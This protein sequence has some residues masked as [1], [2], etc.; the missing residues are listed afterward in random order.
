MVIG[1]GSFSHFVYRH[2]LPSEKGKSISFAALLVLLLFTQTLFAQGP[3][4]PDANGMVAIPESPNPPRLVNDYAGVLSDAEEQQLEAKLVNIDKGGIV[5]IAIVTVNTT[6]L[7]PIEDYSH[8]LF[9]KWGIGQ[10]SKNNGLLLLV[11]MDDRKSDIEVG[12]NL[13]FKVPDAACRQILDEV[14]PYYFKQQQ[15]YAG[16]DAATDSLFKLASLTYTSKTP[17]QETE[18]D[19]YI[20]TSSDFE[21]LFFLICT[22]IIIAV[23]IL[24]FAASRNVIDGGVYPSNTRD[25]NWNSFSSGSGSFNSGSSFGG[26][27]GGSSGGGGASGSW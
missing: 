5:Q 17:V 19:R 9:N 27:G 11:A 4:A 10:K 13:E 14:L 24:A 1:F 25:S 16:L 2:F 3:L 21:Y 26:F 20:R 23:I 7:S 15:Y 8:S 22:I 12:Y 18:V 6:G